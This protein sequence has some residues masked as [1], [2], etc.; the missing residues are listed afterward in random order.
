MAKKQLNDKLYGL[1]DSRGY[2]PD[3]YDSS[4]KK[5]AVP[6]EAELMQFSFIK[7]EKDYGKATVTVDGSHRLIV[8]YNDAIAN[9][10][11]SSTENSD[12]WDTLMKHLRKFAI[13]Y[14][15]G[16]DRK[17]VDEL[18]SDMAMRNHAKT[19]GLTESYHSMGK[20]Q[21]YNDVIPETKIII[22]HSK[23][24]EEGEQRFRNVERI[25]IETALGERILAPTTKPGIAQIYARHIAEGGL[26]HDDRWK[27]INEMC[28]EY[29]KMAGFVR[30]TRNKQFNE[31]AQSLISE[32]VNHYQHLRETLSKMRGKKGYNTYFESWKPALAEDSADVSSLGEM[33]KSS[34]LD[35]R[36]ESV[37]PILSKLS[38]NVTEA[39]STEVV[40]LEEWADNVLS[41]EDVSDADYVDPVEA[42]Y[43]EEYQKTSQSAADAVK[44]IE[45]KLGK[46]DIAKLAAKLNKEETNEG[47]GA[48]QKAA[49]QLG[50]TEKA[51]NN[52]QGKLVGENAEPALERMRK[53]SGL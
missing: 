6:E 17:D 37:M 31:S 32:G 28:E 3:M 27:H 41:F 2:K 52:N 51:S 39:K 45:K 20:K 33:F 19:Q 50:P 35:P 24:M 42:D 36:I 29:S 25:F 14:Q 44:R 23:A 13:N 11:K 12:S 7:D 15:L 49:G 8:Y 40:E 30:A 47:L 4:G 46:V 22:K 18:E 1:L 16:F 5:V 48:E 38:K 26:P 34:S 53:L 10:P 21:S 43:G 9:S